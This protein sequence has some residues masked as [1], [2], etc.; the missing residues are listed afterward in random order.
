[1]SRAAI[2]PQSR[3][4]PS[5]DLPR[6]EFLRMVAPRR[7]RAKVER[8]G[9][10]RVILSRSQAAPAALAALVLAGCQPAVT[11]PD[12]AALS[13]IVL[14]YL[15]A[16][17]DPAEVLQGADGCYWYLYDGPLESTYVPLRT[18]EERF[19]CEVAQTA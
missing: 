12:P 5:A 19:V 4:C 6:R 11:Q 9:V 14:R 3:I 17:A 16:G 8:E 10:A 15:P 7:L 13:P 18:P 2:L 1:M